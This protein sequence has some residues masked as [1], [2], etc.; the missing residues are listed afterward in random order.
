MRTADTTILVRNVIRFVPNFNGSQ[1]YR[2]TTV[3]FSDNAMLAFHQIRTVWPFLSLQSMVEQSHQANQETTQKI[4]GAA[5]HDLISTCALH[6][7]ETSA[8]SIL[9][10]ISFAFFVVQI[11]A[12][13]SYWRGLF[14]L[15]VFVHTLYVVSS[16][17]CRSWLLRVDSP[18]ILVLQ[19]PK[20]SCTKFIF[21][22][23]WCIELPT[24][25]SHNSNS[26]ILPV[27]EFK[28]LSFFLCKNCEFSL[29]FQTHIPILVSKLRSTEMMFT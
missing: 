11:S 2:T 14:R 19:S 27:I 29:L 16:N 9:G 22:D 15:E 17:L 3:D 10:S 12:C 4:F 21:T 20:H 8:V 25:Y 13:D 24:R 23:L 1:T 18:Y 28:S 6:G 26:G 5:L 7:F